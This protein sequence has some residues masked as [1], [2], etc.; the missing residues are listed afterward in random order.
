[1]QQR[2]KWQLC[3]REGKRCNVSCSSSIISTPNFPRLNFARDKREEQ[4]GRGHYLEAEI[5]LLPPPSVC[6]LRFTPA[7]L[8]SACSPLALTFNPLAR[9]RRYLPPVFISPFFFF[10]NQDQES[11][12]IFPR[13]PSRCASPTFCPLEKRY[14]AAKLYTARVSNLGREREREREREENCR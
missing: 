9:P 11:T 14:T 4:K 3:P 1:M 12:A 5:A 7:R 8:P 13:C 6:S 2:S 10:F